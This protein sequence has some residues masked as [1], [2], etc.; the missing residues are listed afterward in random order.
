MGFDA[1]DR[2]ER[3]Q[4]LE[5]IVEAAWQKTLLFFHIIFDDEYFKCQGDVSH[6]AS[7]VGGASRATRA[8]GCLRSNGLAGCGS[9]CGA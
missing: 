3:K 6:G 8:A 1:L 9:T 5:D 2:D 7:H 4:L